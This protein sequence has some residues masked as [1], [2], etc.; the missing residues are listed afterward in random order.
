M[1]S[2]KGFLLSPFPFAFLTFC[3]LR[4][5]SSQRFCVIFSIIVRE[6]VSIFGIVGVQRLANEERKD[7]TVSTPF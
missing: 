3:F 1:R 5:P 6:I 7:R 2:E 4:L